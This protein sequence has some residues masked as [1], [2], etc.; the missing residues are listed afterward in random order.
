MPYRTRINY[1]AKQ[2]EEMWDRWQK[3]ESLTSIGRA[4]DRPSSSIYGLLSPSGGIR[5]PPRQRSRLAL[6]LSE[7]EEISRG[8]AAD[9]SI[10]SIASQLGRSPSTISREINRNGRYDYYRA[11]QA[12]QAA[13]DRSRRPR[14]KGTEELFFDQF[15]G[16][17]RTPDQLVRRFNRKYA[18]VYLSIA[19]GLGQP[20]K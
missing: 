10:R 15:E 6:T 5:P 3:G 2:K 19:Y 4:F 1:T 8:I 17:V 11:S 13:W 16:G 9:R 7:R 20:S 18:S 12:D 14:K